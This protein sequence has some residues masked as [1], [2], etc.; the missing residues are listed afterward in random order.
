MLLDLQMHKNSLLVS[1]DPLSLCTRYIVHPI[2]RY[3]FSGRRTHFIFACKYQ[4]MSVLSA[5]FV[6]GLAYHGSKEDHS[7]GNSKF[8]FL[9]KIS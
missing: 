2:S 9:K 8:P 7:K 5:D 6:G 3:I 1:I 4:I